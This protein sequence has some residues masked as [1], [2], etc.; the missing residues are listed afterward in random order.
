MESASALALLPSARAFWLASAV[1]WQVVSSSTRQASG[2]KAG[3]RLPST[4]LAD[5]SP[6]SSAV[7]WRVGAAGAAAGALMSEEG[8]LA[9]GGMRSRR[10]SGR[11]LL[12]PAAAG[13]ASGAV[14][15]A[16]AAAAEAAAAGGRAGP[17]KQLRCSRTA[18]AGVVGARSG[19]TLCRCWP[20]PLAAAAPAASTAA[21]ATS[22][23]GSL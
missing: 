8:T 10:V 5:G 11:G 4:T 9:S 14:P 19:P 23:C 15:A 7:K 16:A 2:A 17:K 18:A 6:F 12:G 1:C 21:A 3:S 13:G 20:P 22:G